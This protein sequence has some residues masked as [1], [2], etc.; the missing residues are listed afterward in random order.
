MGRSGWKAQGLV[1]ATG[2]KTES[3][4]HEVVVFALRQ[5]G[6]GDRANNSRARDVDGE[7]SSVGGVVFQRQVVSDGEGEAGL[8]EAGGRCGTNSCENARRH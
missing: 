8:L 4:D 3:F 7:A 5:A 2:D 1:V 6:D